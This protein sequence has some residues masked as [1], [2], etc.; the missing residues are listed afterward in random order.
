MGQAERE[1]VPGDLSRGGQGDHGEVGL[2]RVG[3]RSGKLGLTR[4]RASEEHTQT[5]HDHLRETR[6]H[7][8][9]LG[10]GAQ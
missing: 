2:C 8:Y 3:L 10:R 9:L 6:T 5:Q 1:L 7:G 4:C